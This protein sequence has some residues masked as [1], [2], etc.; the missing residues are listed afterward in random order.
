[1]F[2]VPGRNRALI[3][4]AFIF[5]LAGTIAGSRRLLPSRVE[6]AAEPLRSS[7]AFLLNGMSR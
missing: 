6:A 1:M 2:K 5:V 7:A 3:T 4:Y